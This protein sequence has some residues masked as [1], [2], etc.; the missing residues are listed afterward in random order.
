M[1]TNED[2]SPVGTSRPSAILRWSLV[3]DACWSAKHGSPQPLCWY[4]NSRWTLCSK[5][6]SFEGLSRTRKRNLGGQ[7][8]SDRRF[9]G[10]YEQSNWRWLV[11]A[12]G[13][14]IRDNLRRA[15]V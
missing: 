13:C 9:I 6:T 3:R 4:E 10:S 8:V 15:G 5:G 2:V 7:P 12:T 1:R 11:H 14:D